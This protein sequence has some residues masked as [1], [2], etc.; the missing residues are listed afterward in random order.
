MTLAIVWKKWRRR[1]GRKKRRKRRE[2]S[3]SRGAG[4]E[5]E[6]PRSFCSLARDE[7]V[8]WGGGMGRVGGKVGG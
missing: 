4:E 1:R 3:S 7:E 8:R 2:Q 6:G 5:R